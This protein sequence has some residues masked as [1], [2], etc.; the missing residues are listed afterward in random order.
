[1]P[2]FFA[3]DVVIEVFATVSL[4]LQLGDAIAE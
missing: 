3:S 2:F 1:L 4:A